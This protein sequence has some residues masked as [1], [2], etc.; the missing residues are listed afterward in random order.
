MSARNTP[1]EYGWIARLL[2]WTVFLL[3]AAML[4]LGLYFSDLPR[5]EPKTTLMT[6]HASLGVVLVAVMVL[7][8]V[9][10]WRNPRPAHPHG[11]PA[12][13]RQTALWLHRTLYLLIFFQ[14]TVGI[15]I[16]P[17]AGRPLP[18]FGLFE[19]AIPVP[20][21]HDLHEWLE[22]LHALGWKLIA[23]AVAVHVLAALYHHFVARDEVLRRMTVGARGAFA[24]GEAESAPGS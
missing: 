22:V 10:R 19:I 1:A 13:E 23:G 8:L 2:H 15:F 3:I 7:R 9:W 11:R 17:T 16:G 14:M 6:L 20:E 12:W 21:N 4:A 5:G 24:E 18:F